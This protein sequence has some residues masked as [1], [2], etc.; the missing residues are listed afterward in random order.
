MGVH[1]IGDMNRPSLT[2]F[3]LDQVTDGQ[4]EWAPLDEE[5]DQVSIG[6]GDQNRRYP[7]VANKWKEVLKEQ[8]PEE[9]K[10]IDEFFK[11]IDETR[12]GLGYKFWLLFVKNTMIS[13][14]NFLSMF[15]VE[16][17]LILKIQ[18]LCKLKF[19]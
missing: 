1:Y 6:Y 4:I 9:H 12:Y 3:L 7:V 2:K 18:D 11:L 19:W 14:N 13:I 15:I 16:L 10:A 5:F 17:E 8:F